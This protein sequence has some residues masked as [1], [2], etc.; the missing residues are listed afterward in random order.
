MHPSFMTGNM[1]TINLT[2]DSN[3]VGGATEGLGNTTKGV[4]NTAKGVTDKGS[5]TL[6]GKKVCDADIRSME[7]FS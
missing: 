5:E 4:G 7:T 6:G 2:R 1:R 3:T